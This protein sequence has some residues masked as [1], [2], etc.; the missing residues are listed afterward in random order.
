MPT[1]DLVDGGGP[2]SRDAR[3]R[4]A[5]PR[6]ELGGVSPAQA[7]QIAA[8][9]G[10]TARQPR[11]ATRTPGRPAQPG[12]G[13]R[14]HPVQ[15]KSA[16]AV[17][18]RIAGGIV[19]RR[20]REGPSHAATG[21][22][23][24][25]A[26]GGHPIHEVTRAHPTALLAGHSHAKVVAEPAHASTS[27]SYQPRSKS[28]RELASTHY[29]PVPVPPVVLRERQPYPWTTPAH[30]RGPHYSHAQ[31][32]QFGATPDEIWIIDHESG[33]YTHAWN[34]SPTGTG[35]A[36]GLGQ[37]TGAFRLAYLG[38]SHWQSA[39]PRLQIKAMKDYIRNGSV[40]FHDDAG[41]KAYWEAHHSY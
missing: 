29:H 10:Q 33:G 4:P 23:P 12:G 20:E 24:T 32:R 9:H 8:S 5:P 15:P 35:Y 25:P 1:D 6:E 41:A 28:T 18:A 16:A 7:R 38:R 40:H 39:D 30:P 31:L 26:Y 13:A 19:P 2:D 36:F 37:L 27:Y 11:P 3:L 17:S 34:H 22:R 21:F 14:L